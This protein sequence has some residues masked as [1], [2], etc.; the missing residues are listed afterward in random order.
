MST[1]A[2]VGHGPGLTRADRPCY[3]TGVPKHLLALALCLL[4][5]GTAHADSRAWWPVSGKSSVSFDV[6]HRFGDFSGRSEDIRVQITAD[7]ADLRQPVTATITVPAAS[8]KTGSTGR[9]RDVRDALDA[10]QHGEL[11]FVL[12]SA[13]AS[14]PSVSDKGDVLLT[15]KGTL[16]V[17][18]V[19]RPLTFLGRVRQREERLWVRGEATI[20]LTEFG[21]PPLRHWFFKAADEV[22][23]RFDLTLAPA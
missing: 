14:F 7:P 9:D 22:G 5:L 20:K 16:T 17:R 23:L 11:R 21:V 12:E 8:F 1:N 4:A 2:G 15:I 6:R 13:D 18:G 3:P 10:R 19:E